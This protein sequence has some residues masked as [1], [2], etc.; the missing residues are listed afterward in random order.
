LCAVQIYLEAYNRRDNLIISGLS[1]ANYAEA[2]TVTDSANHNATHENSET[3]EKFVLALCQ[4]QLKV[5][6]TP[7]DDTVLYY[8]ILSVRDKK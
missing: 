5:N 7:A 2:A 3:T 8:T 4:Q 6:I 1:L